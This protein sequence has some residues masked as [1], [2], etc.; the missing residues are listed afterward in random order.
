[1]GNWG[2]SVYDIWNRL[3]AYKNGS[4]TLEAMSYDG[5]DRRIV[6]NPGTATD[7]YYSNQWQVLEE[8]VGGTAKVHYVWS[9]MY[10]D[11]LILRDRD[12][13]GG[14]L[15]ERLWVQQDANWDV[16]ALVNG[17]GSVVERYIYDPY[18]IMVVLT[19]SWGSTSGSSYAW[20]YGHQGCRLDTVTGL[21]CFRERD[22]SPALARWIEVDPSGFAAGDVNL[23][24]SVCDSPVTGNDPTGMVDEKKKKTGNGVEILQPVPIP[25]GLS[26]ADQIIWRKASPPS[27]PKPPIVWHGVEP[28]MPR[29]QPDPGTGPPGART[30]PNPIVDD[31]PIVM[32]IPG[33]VKPGTPA[34][35]TPVTII[36]R[37]PDGTPGTKVLRPLPPGS[38]QIG[39]KIQLPVSKSSWWYLNPVNWFRPPPRPEMMQER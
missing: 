1:V 16:T 36:R 37:P 26:P 20:I 31:N 8:R 18:G 32:T 19:A 25:P 2:H 9:P 29:Q 39:I 12:T 23:Y 10:V 13:G 38:A 14:T 17:S 35:I 34:E 3:V 11:A 28:Q 6:A 33:F 21:D 30:P 15:S 22:L 24:R 5:L 27:S 7:L 4:T